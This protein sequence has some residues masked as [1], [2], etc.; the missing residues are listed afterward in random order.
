[1]GDLVPREEVSKQG[2]RAVGGLAA[3]G[4]LLALGALSIGPL[5]WIVGGVLVVAGLVG[6]RSKS[7]RR[8]AML[9]VAAGAATLVGAAIGGG[10]LLTISGIG[11]LAAGGWYGYKFVRN[12]RQ[13]M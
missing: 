12:L 11:L 3:G 6:G 4:L 5:P 13:R 7:N 2:V 9:T 10:T 1:M 8:S